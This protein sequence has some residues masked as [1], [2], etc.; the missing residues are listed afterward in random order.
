M[1][2]PPQ[3]FPTGCRSSSHIAHSFSHCGLDR[4]WTG[5]SL[6]PSFVCSAL[7]HVLSPIEGKIMVTWVPLVFG[8]NDNRGHGHIS[9]CHLSVL[10]MLCNGT[11][12][13][14]LNDVARLQSW[15]SGWWDHPM[16][17]RHRGLIESPAWNTLWNTHLV[18]K[19]C[20]SCPQAAAREDS[21][22]RRTQSFLQ[23]SLSSSNT[24][25]H[26]QNPHFW[27]YVTSLW[28]H[29]QAALDNAL[30]TYL[31]TLNES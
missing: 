28:F 17:T 21:Q 6:K 1:S 10:Q 23:G 26:R 30:F 24:R 2:E 4:R 15:P 7:D 14:S 20:K 9:N 3:P 19:M 25:R 31:N 11:Q 13:Y 29:L 22:R 8:W 5:E 16:V 12:L 27:V 18:I